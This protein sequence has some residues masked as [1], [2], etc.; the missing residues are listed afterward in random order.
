MNY[1]NLS[2]QQNFLN[3]TLEDVKNFIEIA[4]KKI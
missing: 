2:Y 4:I 3:I 1:G